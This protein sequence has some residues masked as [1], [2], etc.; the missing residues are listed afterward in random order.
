MHN[1][2]KSSIPDSNPPLQSTPTNALAPCWRWQRRMGTGMQIKP[3]N[4][5]GLTRGSTH[6]GIIFASRLRESRSTSANC[7][8]F[9]GSNA[10]ISS[11]FRV[12]SLSKVLCVYT[13]PFASSCS[14]S[15]IIQGS[16][17]LVQKNPSFF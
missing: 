17:V 3:G 15:H 9:S 14:T 7:L 11:N 10:S 13:S 1:S 5:E 8:T 2:A 12:Q 6:P 4:R 16:L